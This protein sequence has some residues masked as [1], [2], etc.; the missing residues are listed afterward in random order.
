MIKVN[1]QDLVNAVAEVGLTKRKAAEAVDAML[2]AIKDA[3]RSG[4]KVQLIGFGSFSVRRRASREGR[5]PQTGAPLR[6]PARNV[7]IFRP[8]EALRSAVK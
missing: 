6:I 3:L 5:N 7:P 2:E 4:E 8:G 1:K